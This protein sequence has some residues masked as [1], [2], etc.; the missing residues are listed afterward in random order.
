MGRPLMTLT[1]DSNPWWSI[2]KQAITEAGGKLAKPEILAS[3]TDARYMRQNGHSHSCLIHRLL[4]P[5][6]VA[7][8]TDTS[9]MNVIVIVVMLFSWARLGWDMDHVAVGLAVAAGYS[10]FSPRVDAK[11]A[12]Y[13]EESLVVMPLSQQVRLSAF[14]KGREKNND[15]QKHYGSHYYMDMVMIVDTMNLRPHSFS[16]NLLS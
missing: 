9:L 14:K 4:I 1:N 10:E 11:V 2:F 16:G 15:N 12:P 5:I 13:I 6:A 3:T 8:L 7:P